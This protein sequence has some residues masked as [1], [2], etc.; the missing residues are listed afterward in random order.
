MKIPAYL[1]LCIS[2]L[3]GFGCC[4]SSCLYTYVRKK[5][6]RP[7]PRPRPSPRPRPRPCPRPC[8]PP[9]PPPP[10]PP[11]PPT[12]PPPRL[13]FRRPY[14]ILVIERQNIVTGLQTRATQNKSI[15]F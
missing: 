5:I 11:P 1:T 9:R 10:P 12:H 8:P 3:D 13:L 2:T 7:R 6:T 14:V 4:F 15:P